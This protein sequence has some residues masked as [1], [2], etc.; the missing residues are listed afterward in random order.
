M[1]T[2]ITRERAEELQLQGDTD[3]SKLTLEEC[4]QLDLYV[5]TETLKNF[6]QKL[7]VLVNDK[8]LRAWIFDIASAHFGSVDVDDL[9]THL[10]CHCDL[11][12]ED[13]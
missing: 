7:S 8:K 13:R 12:G 10:K 9:M 2:T 4:R 1:N 11:T 5:K 6:K 3:V